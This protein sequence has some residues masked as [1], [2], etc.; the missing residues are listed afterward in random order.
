MKEINSKQGCLSLMPENISFEEATSAAYGG[1]LALQFLEKKTIKQG[2]KVLIYGSSSTSGIIALQYI[3]HLGA[4]VTSV[5][6]ENK[7]EFINSMAQP[8]DWSSS[9]RVI[10]KPFTGRYWD[11]VYRT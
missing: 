9:V 4:E 8:N 11:R 6:R 1:L 2:D 7:F 5:C 3:K 10:S